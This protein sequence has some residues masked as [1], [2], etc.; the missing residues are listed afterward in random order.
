MQYVGEP[1]YQQGSD[2]TGPT[3]NL[4][5]YWAHFDIKIEICTPVTGK[6]FKS[7]QT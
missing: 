3:P 2:L 4:S 1:V 7:K 5:L 6:Q